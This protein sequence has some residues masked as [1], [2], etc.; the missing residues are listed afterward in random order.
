LLSKEVKD[1]LLNGHFGALDFLLF[2]SCRLLF[3]SAMV[4]QLECPSFVA[5]KS[6]KTQ[7]KQIGGG[8]TNKRGPAGME[9]EWDET[10][11]NWE[12]IIPSRHGTNLCGPLAFPQFP[13]L[14]LHPFL[15]ICQRM[16]RPSMGECV[17]AG[18]YQIAAGNLGKVS[19]T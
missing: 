2:I 1:V 19:P 13:W 6:R 17:G 8:K 4:V 14:P 3:S 18:A 11:S 7:K 5:I 12:V 15:L 10:T 9:K 16:G